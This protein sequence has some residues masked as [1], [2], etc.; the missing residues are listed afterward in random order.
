MAEQS[1][2][3]SNY[4]YSIRTAVRGLWTGALLYN[5]FID[6]MRSTIQAGLT[7]AYAE[8]AAACGIVP[9]EYT[10]EEKIA[11]DQA[12]FREFNYIG[13]FADAI[14]KGDK[15][16]GGKLKP[17]MARAKMWVNRYNDVVNQAK[18]TACK[19]QKLRWMLHL[20]RVTKEPCKDCLKLN[21]RIYR[22]YTWQKWNVRPQS[23][24]LA[25]NGINCGCGF[26]TT[27]E[28]ATPGRPPK[29][30]GQ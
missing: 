18:V 30:A 27:D 20:V 21:G 17:L 16:S 11:L 1:R 15:A 25:C 3:A 2:G 14:E 4:H 8:G 9:S 6:S 19:N 10:L 5:Q 24:D 26:Q 22:A 29:L 12:I 23:P 28:R 13:R 7:R